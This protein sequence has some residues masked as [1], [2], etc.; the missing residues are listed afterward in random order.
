MDYIKIQNLNFSYESK[1]IF[2][3]ISL[4]FQSGKRYVLAG[5]NGCGKSTLLKIIGGK[6]LCPNGTVSVKG[7]DPFRKTIC[8][9]FITYVN[10]EWGM[11]TVAYCGYNIPLQSSI[12]VKEMSQHIKRQFPERNQ[13]L[14]KVLDINEEWRL[15][16][17]SE[18][19]RKRVQLYLNLIKPF[20]ICL[21]DE[22]TV[23]LDILV[24]D[25][26]LQYLKKESIEN[27]SCII[28]VTH[29]FDGLDDWCTNLIYINKKGL[30]NEVPQKEIDVKG[31]IY[32]FLLENFK[33]EEKISKNDWEQKSDKILLN[34]AGGY[35]DG[36]L[37]NYVTE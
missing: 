8:N 22:I 3:N 7:E 4:D 19:Q 31:S 10:N 25:K 29:I 21:L 12:T 33:Q 23:N 2:E 9:S 37:I 36:V 18:G 16:S 6:V 20:D 26:L 32:S 17:I 28:Y 14:I 15:N 30:I 27:N 24:K 11:R 5:L 13:E 1:L 35:S 34:N